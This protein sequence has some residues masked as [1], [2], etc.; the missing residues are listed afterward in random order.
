MIHGYESTTRIKIVLSHLY[1]SVF[2]E[3][4]SVS[5]FLKNKFKTNMQIE[6]SNSVKR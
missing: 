4:T 1:L 5:C 2:E 3:D 6:I